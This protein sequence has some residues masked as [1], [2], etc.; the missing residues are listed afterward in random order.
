M[1]ISEVPPLSVEKDSALVNDPSP[2]EQRTG[3]DGEAEPHVMRQ[4]HQ[5]VPVAY[6]FSRA[7]HHDRPGERHLDFRMLLKKI[8]HGFQGA[9]Q[10]LFV[11]S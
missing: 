8:V 3:E 7:V 4:G 11:R 9:G 1:E 5:R 2:D 6:I 10:I